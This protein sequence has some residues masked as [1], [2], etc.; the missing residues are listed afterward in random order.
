MLELTSAL[1]ITLSPEVSP[2]IIFP[3]VPP[4]KSTLPIKVETPDT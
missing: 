2:K 3:F 1:K 4:L